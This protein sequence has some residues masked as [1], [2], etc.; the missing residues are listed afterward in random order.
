MGHNRLNQLTA[1][2]WALLQGRMQ[3][4]TY[5]LGEHIIRQGSFGDRI[6]II[7]K[8]EASVEL[9][10]P[11][12]HAVLATLGPDDICGDMA[13]LEKGRSTAAVVASDL[14]VETDEILASD[15][16]DLFE[17][18]P[19]LAYRFYLS[20]SVVLARRLRETSRSLAAE[21]MSSERKR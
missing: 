10:G 6:F 4:H 7:R 9:A 2:D 11:S 5:K 1:N 8:G 17:S 20:L 21:V 14:E 12:N 18:F 19:R 3:R 16:R 15:L 13:F